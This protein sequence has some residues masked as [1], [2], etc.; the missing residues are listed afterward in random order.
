VLAK[1]A[2]GKG[3]KWLVGIAFALVLLFIVAVAAL[4]LRSTLSATIAESDLARSQLLSGARVVKG[5]GLG[6]TKE[7]GVQAS[8]DFGAAQKHFAHVHDVL[9]GSRLITLVG[10]LPIAGTQVTAAINLSDIGVHASMGGALVTEVLASTAVQES[11]STK[12]NPMAPGEK[13][14][15]VLQALDPKL[16]QLTGELDAIAAARNR[17]PSK[18]L[19][20]QLSK[21]VTQFDEKLDLGTMRSGLK[22]LRTEEPA[23]RQLLGSAAPQSYLVIQQDP[24]ELRATGGYIGSV[25]FLD[26]DHGKMGPYDPND[27]VAIDWTASGQEVL[28]P[29]GTATHVDMPAPIREAFPSLTSWELRD[30]NWSPDFPTSARNAEFFLRAETGKQVDGVIA[31]DPYFVASLLAIVGPTKVPETG[32]VVDA[33]NFFQT[34][35]NR[36]ELNLTATRKNFLGQAGRAILPKVL[37]LPASKWPDLLQALGSGCANRSVQAYFNDPQ[38]Q[39]VASQARCTGATEPL[40][41]DGVMVNESN[42]GANKDDFWLKRTY[43]LAIAANA[44]GSARHTLHLHYSGLTHINPLLTEYLPY[45][46]WLRVYLPPSSSVVSTAGAKLD[47]AV[48]LGRAVV[49]GWFYVDFNSTTDITIVYDVSAA[50]L[51]VRNHQ[52]DFLWQKQAGRPKDAITVTF[53]PPPGSRLHAIE[54]G[55]DPIQTGTVSTDL[56]VDRELIFDYRP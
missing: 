37:A 40:R 18:G 14:L 8:A 23:L 3:R 15:A 21:A 2:R 51:K 31:I 13:A 33:N 27:V 48:D 11:A 36:I 44:D 22:T 50:D 35:L 7:Q 32:D 28:G 47:P 9:V 38:V 52:L 5:A 29:P 30:S 6:L 34:A 43:A 56:S 45:A 20:P 17:I 1:V 54:L 53:T 10:A 12:V 41:G 26:F 24:A 25:G 46:G 55:R 16:P 49:Q 39:Q 4:R 42:L 19:L